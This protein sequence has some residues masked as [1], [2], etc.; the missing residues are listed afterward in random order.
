MCSHLRN[1]LV[2][3]VEVIKG[4]PSAAGGCLSSDRWELTLGSQDSHVSW[5]P[6][7]LEGGE[8]LLFAL[9]IG[10]A[11]KWIFKLYIMAE[12]SVGRELRK[13]PDPV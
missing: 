7:F 9:E 8:R 10:A 2:S 13:G 12:V 4:K 1:S 5:P 3:V 6:I 11:R